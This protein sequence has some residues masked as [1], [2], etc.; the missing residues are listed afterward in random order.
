[1]STRETSI[2]NPPP[3]LSLFNVSWRPS[4]LPH[5]STWKGG[6][7]KMREKEK[8]VKLFSFFQNSPSSQYLLLLLL[9]LS[10]CVFQGLALLRCPSGCRE[11]IDRTLVKKYEGYRTT[12]P[13]RKT[14]RPREGQR[15]KSQHAV[16]L[17]GRI[18]PRRGGAGIHKEEEEED[19]KK[20]E[21]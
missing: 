9:S 10:V 16:L 15:I 19:Q 2:V 6:P 1:M 8:K 5:S 20:N 14:G 4:H 17:V 7:S 12:T 18:W 21:E 13:N 3:P 11:W